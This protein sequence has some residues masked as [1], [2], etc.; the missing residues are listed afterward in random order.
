MRYELTIDEFYQSLSGFKSMKGQRVMVFGGG[1]HAKVVI[2]CILEQEAEVIGVID[3]KYQG[4]LFGIHKYEAYGPSIA[5]D[6]RIIVAIGDN[7]IRKQIAG[8][9]THEFTSAIHGSSSV[10]RFSKIGR[11]CMILHHAVVQAGAR[12]GNHV[13]LNTG[14]QVDHDCDLSDFVH[15]APGATLCG[16]VTV[17]EGTLIGAGAT[18]LPG[19]KIGAWVTV[20]AGAVV[21]ADIEDRMVVAGI[22]ARK[23][24]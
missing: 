10:S 23:M 3:N 12:I 9:I 15:V 13:I 21:T 22:P 1:G 14:S 17:G 8:N 16:T 4:T 5:P 7:G 2:D 11:G 18:V 20:G 24:K 19:V 6:A